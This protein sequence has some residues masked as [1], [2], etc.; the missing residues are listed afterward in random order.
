M[1]A[2]VEV[3]G[4]T[5]FTKEAVAALADRHRLGTRGYYEGPAQLQQQPD[6]LADPHAV[7]VIVEGEKAGYLPSPANR[8][9]GLKPGA[10]APAD[11]L[12]EM[13][14]KNKSLRPVTYLRT[15]D[16]KEGVYVMVLDGYRQAYVG[17]SGDMRRRI[18]SHWTG[19]KQFDRLLW[20]GVEESV[21]SIDA[22]RALDTTRIFAARTI[23]PDPLERRLEKSFPPD[24]LLNRIG[25]REMTGLRTLFIGAEMKRHRL[26]T[27]SSAP[28]S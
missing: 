14:S 26:T 1:N 28:G 18:K 4:T 27:E 22:F 13:L 5:T 17:Q 3:A 2:C 24:Y 16:D 11:A 23:S 10:S 12:A 7:A 25:G 19:T 21:M 9:T 6:N 15:L 8:G 20:G